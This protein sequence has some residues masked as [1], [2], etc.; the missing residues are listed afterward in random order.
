[1]EPAPEIL[2]CFSFHGNVSVPSEEILKREKRKGKKGGWAP[3]RGERQVKDGSWEASTAS[4]CLRF[5]PLFHSAS[6]VGWT[7][8]TPGSRECDERPGGTPP[9]ERVHTPPLLLL[10]LFETPVRHQAM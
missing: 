3:F 6:V 4:P 5:L 8:V 1:M 7:K 10:D 2:P 9:A